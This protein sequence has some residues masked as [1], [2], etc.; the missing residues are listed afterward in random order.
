MM[1]DIINPVTAAIIR[2]T[3]D[4]DTIREIAKKTGFAYSAVYRWITELAKRDMFEVKDEGNKKHIYAKH[5]ELYNQFSGLIRSVNEADQD[6]VF[7]A[8]IKKINLKVRLRGGTA[9]SLWTRGSY[10]TGDFFD[11]IYMLEVAAKDVDKLKCELD[12]RNLVYTESEKKDARPLVFLST[13]KDFVIEKIEG[14]PVMPLKELVEWGKRLDLDAALEHLDELY[15]LGLKT[16]YSEV[17][18]NV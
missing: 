17:H 4:G 18:T 14:I 5:N 15:N 3:K 2:Q 16:I 8:F 10:I 9:I 1:T 6:R 11:K 13:K 12:K 7:W